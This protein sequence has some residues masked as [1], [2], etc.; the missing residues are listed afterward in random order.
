MGTRKSKGKANNQTRSSP[1]TTGLSQ[2]R[3]GFN[4]KKLEPGIPQEVLNPLVNQSPESG[5]MTKSFLDNKTGV[6]Y[7]KFG[8]TDSEG[9]YHLFYVSGTAAQKNSGK[10]A[11]ARKLEFKKLLSQYQANSNNTS[12]RISDI[13]ADIQKL[14]SIIMKLQNRIDTK[15]TPN[16][17][18]TKTS[19]NEMKFELQ[20]RIAARARL[21]KI[22]GALNAGVKK[23]NQLSTA[24]TTTSSTGWGSWFR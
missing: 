23:G 15:Y 3:V 19:Q 12:E 24:K 10:L 21:E 2:Q 8:L 14:N 18:Q 13:T 16:I 17:Q 20:E 4:F 1:Q 11:M 9:Y 22:R 6:T 7:S 5:V